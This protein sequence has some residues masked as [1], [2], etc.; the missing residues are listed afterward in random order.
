L[1]VRSGLGQDSVWEI[2][3]EPAGRGP[4]LLLR[5]AGVGRNEAAAILLRLD[6]DRAEAQLDRFDTIDEAEAAALLSLWRAD[7]GYRAAIARL[8]A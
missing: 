6:E 8:A 4:V 2:L 7:P 3:S 5:A 1:A